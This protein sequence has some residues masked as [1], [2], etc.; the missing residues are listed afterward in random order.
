VKIKLAYLARREP[1]QARQ[2]AD[3]DSQPPRRR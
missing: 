3:E 2:A 1:E